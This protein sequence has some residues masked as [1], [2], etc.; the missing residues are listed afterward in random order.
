MKPLPRENTI[1]EFLRTHIFMIFSTC[2]TVNSKSHILSIFHRIL[3]VLGLH[4]GTLG[5][6]FWGLVFRS[7]KM[8]KIFLGCAPGSRPSSTPRGEGG[9]WEASGRHLGGI[10]GLRDTGGPGIN[11]HET[12]SKTG[13]FSAKVDSASFSRRQERRDPHRLPHLRTKVEGGTARRLPGRSHRRL[14]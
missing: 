3:S 5:T 7:K 6:T 9:N 14:I 8:Q 12:C 13:V 11:F 10:R 4:F 2:F 1:W